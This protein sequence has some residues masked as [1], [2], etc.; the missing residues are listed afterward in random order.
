MNS[1]T[2]ARINCPGPP[3]PQ[4][5]ICCSRLLFPT[6]STECHHG[7]LH[8]G[9]GWEFIFLGANIDVTKE[10]DSLGITKDNAYSFD[11]CHDGVDAMYCLIHDKVSEKRHSKKKKGT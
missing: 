9:A 4:E 3:L 2:K 1:W 11:A 6:I 8:G 10:A 7:L 5:H